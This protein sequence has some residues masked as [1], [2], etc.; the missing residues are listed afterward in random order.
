[1]ATKKGNPKMK[2][3]MAAAKRIYKANPRKKW[4]TCV[5]EGWKEVK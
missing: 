1:M 5:K 4:T 3:A 2:K